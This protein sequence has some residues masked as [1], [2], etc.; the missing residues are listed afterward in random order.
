MDGTLTNSEIAG[1]NGLQ[2]TVGEYTGSVY[3]LCIS[4]PTDDESTKSHELSK[5]KGISISNEIKLGTLATFY[6]LEISTTTTYKKNSNGSY[7]IT[8]KVSSSGNDK[9]K[10]NFKNK[11]Y[12]FTF[13]KEDSTDGSREICGSIEKSVGS[14]VDN[15][16][17]NLSA[18]RDDFGFVDEIGV[19]NYYF[20]VSDN[21]GNQAPAQYNGET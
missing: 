1:T 13:Y 15:F 5:I 14:S 9:S 17:L 11:K 12:K 20:E 21:K 19:I 2:I 6:P 16:T 7:E 18:F 8:L 4:V 3:Y 10:L